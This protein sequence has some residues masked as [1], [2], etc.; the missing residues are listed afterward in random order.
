MAVTN[1]RLGGSTE[2][3]TELTE[4]SPKS[5]ARGSG[6]FQARQTGWPGSLNGHRR[7]KRGLVKIV[8]GV[9]ALGAILD[10]DEA[11]T[12]SGIGRYV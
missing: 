8:G 2:R 1:G 6:S 4:C 11:R 10:V 9:G 12:A 3:S 5:L 7:R